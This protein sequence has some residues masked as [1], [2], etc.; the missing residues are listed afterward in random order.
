MFDH[1]ALQ[2]LGWA[3][4]DSPQWAEAMYG[5]FR[6]AVEVTAAQRGVKRWPD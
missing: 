4:G 1:Q 6:E 5:R 2:F 3:P